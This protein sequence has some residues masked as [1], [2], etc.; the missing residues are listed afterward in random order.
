MEVIEVLWNSEEKGIYRNCVFA[1]FSLSF[2]MLAAA[3]ERNQKQRNA[4]IARMAAHYSPEQLIFLDE[5]AKDERTPIRQYG[6][7]MINTRAA[8]SVVFVR[9]KRYSI[10]ALSITVHVIKLVDSVFDSIRHI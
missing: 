8:K 5:T 10:T 6:Y 2:I 1:L 7:S 3:K 9:G 4:F